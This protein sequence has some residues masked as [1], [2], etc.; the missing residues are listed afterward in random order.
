V[1]FSIVAFAAVLFIDLFFVFSPCGRKNEEQKIWSTLLPFVLS[2]PALSMSK[3][4]RA[5]EQATQLVTAFG[6]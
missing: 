3:G 2:L 6:L 1:L 4:R 5:G